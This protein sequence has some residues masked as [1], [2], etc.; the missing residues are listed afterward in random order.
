MPLTFDFSLDVLK[1]Y[2]G[3]NPRPADF[4]SYWDAAL[5]EM[6]ALDPQVELVPADFHAAGVE[7]FDLYF[8]GVGG[9]RVHA[10]LL[11]PTHAPKPHPAVL[12]FHG[13]TGNAGDWWDK[14]A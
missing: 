4:D 12:Q 10:K 9:A 13:Y 6:H 2:Q 7:A 8:T 1:T 14:M 11:R 5:T 3:R